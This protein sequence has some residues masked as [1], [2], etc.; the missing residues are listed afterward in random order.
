[1]CQKNEKKC[2]RSTV[3]ELE[4][5]IHKGTCTVLVWHYC[6]IIQRGQVYT[7]LLCPLDPSMKIA[8]MHAAHSL[9]VTSAEHKSSETAFRLSKFLQCTVRLECAWRALHVAMSSVVCV[10]VTVFRL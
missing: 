5:Y 2:W 4:R 10:R 6:G 9:A 3:T 8:C 1:M 7:C